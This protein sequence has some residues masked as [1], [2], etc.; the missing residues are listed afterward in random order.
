[1]ETSNPPPID[2]ITPS[3]VS[4][5]LL[6][7]YR[8]IRLLHK[9]FSALLRDLPLKELIHTLAPHYTSFARSIDLGLQSVDLDFDAIRWSNQPLEPA[10]RD[11]VTKWAREVVSLDHG[12]VDIVLYRSKKEARTHYEP[13]RDGLLFAGLQEGPLSWDNIRDISLYI[14]SLSPPSQDQTTAKNGDTTGQA[15]RSVSLPGLTESWESVVQTS[16]SL[17]SALSFG[18]VPARRSPLVNTSLP[19]ED[20]TT[21]NLKTKDGMDGKE[22][23]D[24]GEWVVGGEES[25]QRIWL[26]TMGEETFVPIS[27]GNQRPGYLREL[28]ASGQFISSGEDNLIELEMHIHKA[29]PQPQPRPTKTIFFYLTLSSLIC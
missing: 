12:V 6:N 14:D 29:P 26:Q 8:K 1:V 10:Q 20:T 23:E 13:R 24:M 17:F 22:A 15:K 21:A 27:L 3:L 9:P 5:I 28:S 11:S 4:K 7:G 18:T 25:G 2:C 19:K 16:S